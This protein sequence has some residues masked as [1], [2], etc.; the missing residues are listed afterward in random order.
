MD[1]KR[2][3]T[4]L[5]ILLGAFATLILFLLATDP[6]SLPVGLVFLP[7]ILLYLVLFM[8]GKFLYDMV[9]TF[10]GGSS[11]RTTIFAAIFALIPTL[12]LV[13]RS[14]D[15][16]TVKDLFLLL[17]LGMV[18]LFYTSVIKFGKPKA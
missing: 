16:L 6:N 5:L 10:R 2:R 12:L 3:R 13:L 15:Q 8:S 17:L 14:I 18:L 9:I 1:H 4:N 11:K 7:L